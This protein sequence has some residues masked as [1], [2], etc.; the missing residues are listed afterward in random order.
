MFITRSDPDP[1][2]AGCRATDHQPARSP[3]TY[4]LAPYWLNTRVQLSPDHALTG[5]DNVIKLTATLTS[6]DRLYPNFDGV[7]IAYLQHDF[8][9][10]Y[11]YDPTRRTLVRRPANQHAGTIPAVRCTAGGAHCLGMYF[12]PAAM[13]QAYYYTMTRGPLPSNGMFGEYTMQVTMPFRNVGAGGTTSLRP[14]LYLAVGNAARVADTF[15]VLSE[16]VR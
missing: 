9:E 14:E 15:R 10:V 6:E 4:G 8:T 2:W 16:R 1:G 13:P 3:Y 7:L 5:L 12:R 11:S